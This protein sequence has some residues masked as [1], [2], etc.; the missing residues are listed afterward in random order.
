VAASWYDCRN[1]LGNG[2]VNDLDG[3]PNTDVEMFGSVSFDGDCF[4]KNVQISP[5]PSSSELNANSGNDFADY[6]GLAFEAGVFHP[7]W[8]DNSLALHP[9]NPDPPS[10]EIATAAIAVPSIL[11]QNDHEGNETSD[12]ATDQGTISTGANQMFEHLGIANLRNGLLDFDWSKWTPA[13]AGTFSVTLNIEAAIGDTE[14]HLF[15]LESD[16]TLTELS[17]ASSVGS[18]ECTFNTTLTTAATPGEILLVEV[19]GVNSARGVYGESI[20]D[21]NVRFS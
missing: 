8:T 21:L 19:K 3:I 12:V 20:Y 18:D 16:N 1:D 15:R 9:P 5:L 11:A 13:S 14:I 4:I 10:M 6:T 2:G 17:S 7:A